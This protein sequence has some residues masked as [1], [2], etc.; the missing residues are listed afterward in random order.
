METITIIIGLGIIV[1]NLIPFFFRK[2]D[3][4]LVTAIISALILFLLR[5]L[6]G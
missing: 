5:S 1:L 4:L 3:L 6:G 2:P